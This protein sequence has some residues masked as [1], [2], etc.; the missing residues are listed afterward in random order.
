MTARA[1]A[2]ALVAAVALVGPR[3][4]PA[5]AQAEAPNRAAAAAHTRQGQAYFSRGDYDR[6]IA[7]YQAAFELSGEPSLI[8]NV[9]LCY[10][11]TDRPE[12]A[13]EAFQRYLSLAPA[14]SVADEARDDVARLV[15][16][17][18]KLRA[19]R[20]AGEARRRDEAARRQAEAREAA[21][22]DE[23]AAA[24]RTTI[25]RALLIAGAAFVAGGAA[26]HVVAWRT[27][28]RLTHAPDAEAY[29]ADHDSFVLQRNLAIGAYA[30]GAAALATGAI[31][32]LTARRAS[33]A[34]QVSAAIVPGGA[35]M[36]IAWS[37]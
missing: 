30:V 28:D 35:T 31:F 9:A 26:A 34:A 12:P 6:A 32:A 8:F 37:R 1:I 4:E 33:D 10:D 20:A 14:G 27:R 5:R 16:I 13:L 29:F 3:V 21:A 23:R 17:V 36:V 24:R 2:A 25:S 19:D 11:R 18:E 7:E 22:R 15:P